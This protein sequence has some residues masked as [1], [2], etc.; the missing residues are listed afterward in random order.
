M[1]QVQSL[2]QRVLVKSPWLSIGL[3]L[4]F[5]GMIVF[6]IPAQKAYTLTTG[7]TVFL[8]TVPVDPYDLLRG[9]YV[10]LDYAA[11]Q[12][13]TLEKLPGWSSELQEKPVVYL[14]LKPG[15]GMRDPWIPVGI[16][17]QFP[18]TIPPGYQVIQ[19]RWRRWG[20]LDFGL[21][22][23]FIPE[24]IGDGLEADLRHHPQ[25]ARAEVKVDAQGKSALVQL[26]VEDRSY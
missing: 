16:H 5:Q 6:S 20:G 11:A 9:R 22:Q 2:P 1:V 10:T 24:G 15:E 4:L 13:E 21:S 23:Y 3:P 18:E 26:W 25:A 14:T 8:Q 12:S 19:G 7:T 17:S